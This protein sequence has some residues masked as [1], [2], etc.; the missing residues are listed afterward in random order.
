MS[1]ERVK[2]PE[3]LQQLYFYAS[4]GNPSDADFRCEIPALIERI[5]HSEQALAA[6]ETQWWVRLGKFRMA[7]DAA[8]LHGHYNLLQE[9]FE[10]E[11]GKW[12]EVQQQVAALEARNRELMDVVEQL[13]A[14]A[15]PHPI[16][17]PTMTKAWAAAR[18]ALKGA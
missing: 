14:S 6:L 7:L 5:A 15:H 13:L 12:E 18:A 4:L 11:A 1:D 10:D 2:I 3:D 17:H 16:E 9:H 8:N